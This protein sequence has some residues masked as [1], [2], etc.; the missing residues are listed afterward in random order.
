MSLMETPKPLQLT[1]TLPV[2]SV[3]FPRLRKWVYKEDKEIG[4]RYLE[5][6]ELQVEEQDLFSWNEVADE[7]VKLVAPIRRLSLEEKAFWG[8][9]ETLHI[10][11]ATNPENIVSFL[12]RF[13]QVGLADELRRARFN[14]PLTRDG[15][16][17]TLQQFSA[18]CELGSYSNQAKEQKRVAALKRR[19]NDRKYRMERMNRILWGM[20]IPLAWVE[21]DIFDL[22]KC[23]RILLSLDKKY[24]NSS[25]YFELPL[26]RS[27]SLRDFLLAAQLVAI[28]KGKD[29]N[30]KPLGDG[31][32]VSTKRIEG[33]WVD[34]A[35][36]L[37]RFLLP[38]TR[39]TVA[40]EEMLQKRQEVVGVE[41]W[42][43]YSIL[44]SRA[45]YSEQTCANITCQRLF[46]R[47]K[48]TKKYCDPK[49]QT[50]VRVRRHRA[51]KKSSG[52]SQR[53]KQAK[54]KQKNG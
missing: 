48:V 21:K 2:T 50:T 11:D 34:F 10:R 19:F 3:P 13:G 26:K 47:Q 45:Q 7:L 5:S 16:E 36:N 37:N 12:N 15:G 24:L 35:N 42:L 22:Y 32:N 14:R 46:I 40:T 4:Y 44:E 23:V 9:D 52:K 8:E 31:W 17:L 38:I 18:L 27:A 25:A 6:R 30:Y 28:P 54:G 49:C 20:E 33:A 53:K 29:E 39:K 51:K 43:A 41:T 1:V